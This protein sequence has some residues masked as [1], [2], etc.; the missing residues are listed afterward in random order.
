MEQTANNKQN[1]NK[2]RN[3]L[4]IK[5]SMNLRRPPLALQKI[6]EEKLNENWAKIPDEIRDL[7]I[8]NAN[9]EFIRARC[10]EQFLLCF[11]RSAQHNMELAETKLKSFYRLR[12]KYPACLR[13]PSFKDP[14]F[15]EF[16]EQGIVLFLPKPIAEDGPM[17]ILLRLSLF[18]VERNTFSEVMQNLH[19]MQ[20]LVMLEEDNATIS[21]IIYLI[22]CEN[23]TL[24][25]LYNLLYVDKLINIFTDGLPLPVK[26]V[27]FIHEPHL[28]DVAINIIKFM[29][30]KQ[31]PNLHCHGSN[32]ADL[33]KTIPQN[34]LP[35]EYG[36]SYRNLNDL[37]SYCVHKIYSHQK[38]FMEDFSFG[39]T[40]HWQM[41]LNAFRNETT[42][43]RI[44]EWLKIFIY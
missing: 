25:N 12:D 7:R 38:Y 44:L 35:L 23:I 39:T 17:I 15:K 22:D 33:Y 20:E 30:K 32:L 28:L 8:W 40:L 41:C 16:L 36:G 13:A 4:L 27:H 1:K 21:G 10:D 29:F 6:A 14:K 19:L 26:S 3:K 18:S 2:I 43:Y 34:I 42:S 37:V 24:K 11:L 31:I 9:N 5:T